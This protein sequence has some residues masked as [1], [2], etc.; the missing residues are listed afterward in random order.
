M[1]N[2]TNSL[3][4]KTTTTK[5]TKKDYDFNFLLRVPKIRSGHW[6]GNGS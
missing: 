4:T 1:T 2:L 6:N 5:S 3:K